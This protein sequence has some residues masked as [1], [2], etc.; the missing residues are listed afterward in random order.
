MMVD[1]LVFG[2]TS[3]GAD[4]TGAEASGMDSCADSVTDWMA[5]ERTEGEATG[6]TLPPLK[7]WN[8]L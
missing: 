2:V 6:F 7:D 1:D 8:D 3:T 5:S 4:V